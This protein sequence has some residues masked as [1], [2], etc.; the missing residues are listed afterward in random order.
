MACG[1]APGSVPFALSHDAFVS[2]A[3]YEKK[4]VLVLCLFCRF[5]DRDLFVT[6]IYDMCFL[7]GVLNMTVYHSRVYF[8]G[9]FSACEL[10]LYV[11]NCLFVCLYCTF[12]QIFRP[13][14]EAFMVF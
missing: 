11:D 5:C 4:G 13:R 3:A 8:S 7:G 12:D 14:R 10:L 6:S 9:I 2:H 1:E